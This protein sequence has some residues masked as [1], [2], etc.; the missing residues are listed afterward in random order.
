MKRILFYAVSGDL[1]SVLEAVERDGP[2]QY[3]RTGNTTSNDFETFP[4]GAD[5]PN[6]G[7]ADCDTGSTCEAFLVTATSV[8]ATVRRIEG[9]N[10]GLRYCMDQLFNPDTVAFTPAG[11]WGDDVVL[12]GQVATASGSPIS[13]ELMKRFNSAFKQR[14]RKINAYR[15]GPE[16]LTLFAAGKRLTCSAQ[17]PREFDLKTVP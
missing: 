13:Q 2:L 16:A 12:S 11:L 6:L 1:L 17:S 14:F 4:R 9:I 10:G 8:P 3:I 5:I 7:R 15:V